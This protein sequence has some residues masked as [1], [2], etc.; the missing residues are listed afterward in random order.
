MKIKEVLDRAEDIVLNQRQKEYSQQSPTQ[1]HIQIAQ[2]WSGILDHEV[3]PHE[4]ALCMAGMKLVRAVCQPGHEDSY[5][6]AV[7]YA[8]IAA[9]I[10]HEDPRDRHPAFGARAHDLLSQNYEGE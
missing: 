8:C 10:L 1:M 4:V 2:V 3:K 9:E 5:V 7:G 6:D